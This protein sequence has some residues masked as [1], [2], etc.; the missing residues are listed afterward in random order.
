M[1]LDE[2]RGKENRGAPPLS[3]LAAMT[4]SL[5][6]SIEF[7]CFPHLVFQKPWAFPL[8]LLFLLLL[9]LLLFFLKSALFLWKTLWGDLKD[10][11]SIPFGFLNEKP[12]WLVAV[13]PLQTLWEMGDGP[14]VSAVPSQGQRWPPADAWDSFSGCV[15]LGTSGSASCGA[16]P[17]LS[18]PQE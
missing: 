1:F 16:L 3:S 5:A 7:I 11:A 10:K 14:E 8:L 6:E 2:K 12:L 15:P 13:Q 17:R 4:C 18:F 9:S